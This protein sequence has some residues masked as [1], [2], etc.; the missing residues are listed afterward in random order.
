VNDRE[1]RALAADLYAAGRE[2]DA[3]HAHHLARWRDVEP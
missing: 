3:Q 1:R 2:H